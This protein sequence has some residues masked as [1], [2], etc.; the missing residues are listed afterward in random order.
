MPNQHLRYAV[1]TVVVAVALVV[2][3]VGPFGDYWASWKSQFTSKWEQLHETPQ[4]TS[5][6]APTGSQ[7]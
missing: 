5:T 2:F 3:D 7:P 1:V 4:P 6:P